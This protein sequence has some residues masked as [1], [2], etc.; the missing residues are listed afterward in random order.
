MAVD[1][2]QFSDLA[3]ARGL[4]DTDALAV[5]D[6]D[7]LK[8]RSSRFPV[9]RWIVNSGIGKRS[10]NR[11]T[12]D[13]FM[14]AMNDQFGRE[15]VEKM[16]LDSLRDLQRRG[17][18][19]HVRHVRNSVEQAVRLQRDASVVA[20]EVE[21][22]VSDSAYIS[23]PGGAGLAREVRDGVDFHSLFRNLQG[24]L[25]SYRGPD[26]A[27]DVI[28][29]IVERLA[30]TAHN[31]AFRKIFLA[32]Y[33][34]REE[35]RDTSRLQRVIDDAPESRQLLA[36]YGMKLDAGRMP[37]AFFE[38][39][40]D[41]LHRTVD[42]AMLHPERLAQDD[43]GTALKT[44]VQRQAGQVAERLARQ[45]LQERL[46]AL[47]A[48]RQ[49]LADD[50]AHPGAAPDPGLCETLLY[51]RIPAS[52]MPGLMALRKEMPDGLGAL[53]APD[54]SLDD[55][56][57]LLYDFGALVVRTITDMTPEQQEK[58]APGPESLYFMEECANLLK[59]GRLGDAEAAQLRRAL[60]AGPGSEL[61]DLY[62]SL[63]DI[64]Y[65]AECNAT[66]SSLKTDPAWGEAYRAIERVDAAF[67]QLPGYLQMLD[68]IDVAEQ[69]SYTGEAL[70]AYNAMRSCGVNL[71]PPPEG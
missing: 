5:T 63:Q 8:L 35:D 9:T 45:Y 12:V 49:T 33:G 14:R 43:A 56:F 24:E 17:K 34:A 18:P 41:K 47:G 11:K 67:K 70:P 62:Q 52:R 37:P 42:K 19:L 51:N 20:A 23:E 57:R 64:K 39:L 25:D 36:D 30:T 22:R 71:P 66:D 3:R 26:R 53:A 4:R 68:D 38:Q 7:Q 21:R 54:R 32:G 69:R 13:A 48:L 61:V 6:Q 50:G 31:E 59:Q 27:W 58:Y 55:K 46:E 60:C 65:A 28:P 16:E 15:L 2:K 29:G 40:A 1:L 10:G 44:R